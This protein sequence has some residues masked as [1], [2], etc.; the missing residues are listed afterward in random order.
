MCTKRYFL[1]LGEVVFVSRFEKRYFLVS[2]EVVL[3]SR[4]EVMNLGVIVMNLG[5]IHSAEYYLVLVKFGGRAGVV[6]LVEGM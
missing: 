5:V 1:V 2:G 4:F 3:V 6:W